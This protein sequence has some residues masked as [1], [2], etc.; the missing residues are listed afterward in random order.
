MWI[1]ILFLIYQITLIEEHELKTNVLKK[2]WLTI[3]LRRL[4]KDFEIDLNPLSP[5]F[6][7]HTFVGGLKVL[8]WGRIHI[9]DNLDNVMI[10]LQI[11][12]CHEHENNLIDCTSVKT[13]NLSESFL[14]TNPQ[15]SKLDF[16]R[17]DMEIYLNKNPYSLL[18]RN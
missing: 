6:E 1:I 7:T 2:I 9:L 16:I 11:S 18:F 14:D 3:R 17:P 15:F 10:V 5:I 8:K 4:V 13:I 12:C